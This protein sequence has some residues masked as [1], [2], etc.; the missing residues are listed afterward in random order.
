MIIDFRAK[1][2]LEG[3]HLGVLFWSEWRHGE[4]NHKICSKCLDKKH[5]DDFHKDKRKSDGRKSQCKSCKKKQDTEYRLSNKE[6]VAERK[7]K[8]YNNNKKH[9]KEKF[10]NYYL[11]NQ[12]RI[13]GMSSKY[14]KENRKKINKWFRN[15]N[16][17]RLSE[18]VTYR[19]AKNLRSRI[20]NI[21]RGRLK[22]G[23]ALRD[24]GC[25]VEFLIKHLESQFEPGMSW[26]NYGQWHIDHIKPL[27][28]FNL[29]I[30]EEFLEACHYTNL[31]PLWAEDNLKKGARPLK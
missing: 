17:K 24:L 4:M 18:D 23:S 22:S 14:A 13:K 11:E 9:I 21:I 31:Q 28:S 15:Y 19:L 7:K 29:E 16:K 2:G 1:F 5:I 12:E 6:L 20:N 30:R 8:Y 27:A 26:D 10:K 25:S 3:L